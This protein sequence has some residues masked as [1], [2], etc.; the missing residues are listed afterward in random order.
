MAQRTK[1]LADRSNRN[2]IP[3]IYKVNG[4]NW[5][6]IVTYMSW[7][8]CIRIINKCKNKYNTVG[9][10]KRLALKRLRFTRTNLRPHHYHKEAVCLDV[11]DAPRTLHIKVA[12]EMLPTPLSRYVPYS[13]FLKKKKK[14]ENSAQHLL[15]WLGHGF[16][17][18]SVV[19]KEILKFEDA[20]NSDDKLGKCCIILFCRHDM[21]ITVLQSEQLW[22]FPQGQYKMESMSIPSKKRHEVIKCLKL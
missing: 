6:Q 18:S 13:Q 19:W 3:R 22:L 5:L 1:T 15:I 9:P 2:L 16:I 4:K 21:A 14:T 17:L 12:W 10:M 11:V 8:K 20:P 7:Q